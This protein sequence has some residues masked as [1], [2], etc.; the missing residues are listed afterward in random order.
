M[1]I[2]YVQRLGLLATLSACGVLLLVARLLHLQIVEHDHYVERASARTTLRRSVP[3]FRGRIL[4]AD[5]KSLAVDAPAF[6][7]MMRVGEFNGRLHI[8][9]RCRWRSYPDFDA[10]IGRFGSP[11][12]CPRCRASSADFLHYADERDLRHV[13]R[14]LRVR[15]EDLEARIVRQ[16]EEVGRIIERGL[17]KRGVT[18]KERAVA[19][20][21]L[22]RDWEHR[23]RPIERNVSFE[24]VREVEMHPDRNPFLH[25][26]TSQNRL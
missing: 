2:S 8:C 17:D 3:G 16:C 20:K 26:R 6:D 5:T 14:C 22:R 12:I 9:S 7:L 11:D 21:Q 15:L 13:A 4:D 19:A 10:G 25:V 23:L 1:R 24:V 18:G